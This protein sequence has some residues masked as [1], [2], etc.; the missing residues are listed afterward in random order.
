MSSSYHPIGGRGRKAPYESLTVRV[1]EPCSEFVF[2]L[3]EDYRRSCV[4]GNPCPPQERL[5]EAIEILDA[6]LKLPANKGGAIK[7]EIRTAL[8]ILKGFQP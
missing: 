7:T 6:A 5:E 2:Q 1:P 4:T 8:E 3:T